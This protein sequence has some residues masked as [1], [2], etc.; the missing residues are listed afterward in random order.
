MWMGRNLH[1]ANAGEY[2]YIHTSFPYMYVCTY[3]H[4]CV[5]AHI[6]VCVQVGRDLYVANAGDSRTI[7]CHGKR[8]GAALKYACIHTRIYTYACI[9]TKTR[10][11]YLY[12]RSCAVSN[13]NAYACI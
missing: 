10:R 4:V 11:V 2:M 12:A 9:D 3:I 7:L 1:V 8:G 6:C 13:I 5:Y